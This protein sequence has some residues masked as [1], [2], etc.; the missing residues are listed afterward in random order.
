MCELC[1]MCTC[2]CAQGVP[3]CPWPSFVQ[4]ISSRALQWS[5]SRLYQSVNCRPA[6]LHNPCIPFSSTLQCH[7]ASL[8]VL[9]GPCCVCWYLFIGTP[10][11]GCVLIRRFMHQTFIALL[12]I[13]ATSAAC[14]R[15][16]NFIM[17]K[18]NGLV[19]RPFKKAHFTRHEDK[20]LLYLAQYL[21][22]I[23]SKSK[24]S[25]LDHRKWES[26]LRKYQPSSEPDGQ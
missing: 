5:S 15:R 25:H 6:G 21:T 12:L 20:E 2:C 24:I 13:D 19:I 1:C 18:Q 3:P 22:L 10:P 16:R 14:V 7:Y 17:N 11:A 23:G 9:Y 8:H 26:Y 4:H